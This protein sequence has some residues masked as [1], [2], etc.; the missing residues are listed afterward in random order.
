M[1]SRIIFTAIILSLILIVGTTDMAS[2]NE[3]QDAKIKTLKD[4]IKD[5]KDKIK[6]QKKEIKVLKSLSTG[7]FTNSCET[8]SQNSEPFSVNIDTS[9]TTVYNES[10]TFSGT[11]SG[12]NEVGLYQE[13]EFTRSIVYPDSSGDWSFD[14]ILEEG[15]NTLG[16]FVT[17]DHT[18][19]SPDD[20]IV[21]LELTQ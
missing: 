21:T 12:V 18:V 15:E 17:N 2:A 19:F 6:E 13:G 11:S 8:T 7:D 20:I 3:D 10:F 16:V 14:V 4:K 5:L 1:K 9:S